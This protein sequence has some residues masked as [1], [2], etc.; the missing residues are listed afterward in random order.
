MKQCE[1]LEKTVDDLDLSNVKVT[2][3]KVLP[4]D[5]Q[6]VKGFIKKWHYL[7]DAPL[8]ISLVF[9][10]YYKQNLIGAMIYG[11]LS[12][13]NTYKKYGDSQDSIIELK[14][15]CCIDKT[16][17]NTESYFISR[18]LKFI[19][20]YTKYKTVVSYSD[21]FY[22]HLGTIYKA[23]N[24]LHKGFTAKSKVIKWKDKFY[25]D[26]ALRCK[27]SH[28]KLKPFTYEIKEALQL[29]QAT[30]IHKPPKHIYCYEIKRKNDDIPRSK[31]LQYNQMSLV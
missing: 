8:N 19:K 4:V 14:R 3:F 21:P 23:S 7:G 1:L 22:N 15:L 11:S 10:L 30:Y 24:F 18:T 31:S 2:E 16:K 28:N 12:M 25:H 9:G 27:D 20:N 29:G 17:K 6:T 26:K 5:F 13:L